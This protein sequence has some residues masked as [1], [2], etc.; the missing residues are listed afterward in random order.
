MSFPE[1]WKT[2]PSHSLGARGLCGR[3]IPRPQSRRETAGI[4]AATLEGGPHRASTS[5]QP[6]APTPQGHQE[7]ATYIISRRARA[8][9][10]R[11]RSARAG[12]CRASLERGGW[13]PDPWKLAAPPRSRGISEPWDAGSPPRRAGGRGGRV[14]GFRRGP[15][16]PGSSGRL[17]APGAPPRLLP[18]PPRGAPV[19]CLT[20]GL[21][22]TG[23]LSPATDMVLEDARAAAAVGPAAAEQGGRTEPERRA[24]LGPPLFVP[25][26][27]L[28]ARGAELR[29]VTRGSCGETPWRQGG[30]CS[31]LKG[32]GKPRP[33]AGFSAAGAGARHLG[34]WRPPGHLVTHLAVAACSGGP[35]AFFSP[36]VSR[37]L[38]T[39]Q[40][41]L[42]VGNPGTRKTRVICLASR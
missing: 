17:P 32:R 2:Q 3:R 20:W 18:T 22:G 25:P 9:G 35:R 31:L 14:G 6:G 26:P 24:V 42:Q 10:P 33:G 28:W 7:E 19:Q 27:G 38:R 1:G 39:A 34:T 37:A 29:A 40:R 8:P 36:G 23:F 30:W 5:R 4:S 12:P 16:S 11:P 15:G 41:Q 13:K 21:C